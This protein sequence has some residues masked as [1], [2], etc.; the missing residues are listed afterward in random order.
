MSFLA[1]LKRD[2]KLAWEGYKD[3]KKSG[4]KATME[5]CAHELVRIADAME[6]ER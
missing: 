1:E 3:A 2:Y 5:H 6:R 4:D